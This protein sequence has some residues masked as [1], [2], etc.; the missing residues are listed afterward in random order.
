MPSSTMTRYR[1]LSG[2]SGVRRYRI[3]PQA[4]AVEFADGSRYLYTA[5]SAGAA[6]IARMQAL[7]EAG[8]GLASYI[9]RHAHDRYESKLN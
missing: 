3:E 2:D 4:I 5:A 8:R 7:A 6:H 9:N 1:N